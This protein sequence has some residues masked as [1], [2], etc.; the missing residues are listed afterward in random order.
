MKARVEVEV[1]SLQEL[2]QHFRGLNLLLG[3]RRIGS[4]ITD[5]CHLIVSSTEGDGDAFVGTIPDDTVDTF[6]LLV[7][8][9]KGLHNKRPFQ[10]RKL[11]GPRLQF[12]KNFV[13]FGNFL[14]LWIKVF[15]VLLKVLCI[16]FEK[17]LEFRGSEGSSELSDTVLDFVAIVDRHSGEWLAF[18]LGFAG[19]VNDVAKERMIKDKMSCVIL[20]CLNE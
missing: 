18:L 2:L 8:I 6:S 7:L 11:I 10:I 14:F 20:C 15:I 19:S 13:H 4:P 12:I 3:N 1:V 16:F 5:K 17:G 9:I